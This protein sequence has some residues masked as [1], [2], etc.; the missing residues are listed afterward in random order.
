[1]KT[2]KKF[3]PKVI[4]QFFIDHT[5][6]LV[7]G[8][9]ALLFIYFAYNSIELN[10][11][12]AYTKKPDDLKKATD[13]ASARINNSTKD[14][15]VVT[16]FPAYA[17]EIDE[18][19]T[20]IDPAAYP[21]PPLWNW[22]P[23]APRRL[24]G[25]PEVFPV[26]NLRAIPGRG[27]VPDAAGTRGKRWIEITGLVPF[28]KE[29]AEYHARFDGAAYNDL[30]NDMPK[31]AGYFVQ[32]AEVTPGSEPVWSKSKF[33][34]F[35]PLDAD[36]MAG[37]PA[38]EVADARFV[39]RGLTA[40][41][42]SL[43]DATWGLDAVSPPQI[44]LA[45]RKKLVAA[46]TT[47]P[48]VPQFRPESGRR[49]RPSSTYRPLPST[50][51]GGTPAPNVVAG[52]GLLKDEDIDIPGTGDPGPTGEKPPPAP[53]YLLLRFLDF[54]VKPNKQYQYRIFLVLWN[55]NYGLEAGVLEESE[56]AESPWLGLKSPTPKLND[57]G[58][59][60]D[61]PTN[62][63]YAKWSAP[64]T[65]STD[66]GRHAAPG[67]TG[68]LRQAPARKQCGSARPALDGAVRTQ[69]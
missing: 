42:P 46:D 22:K 6:K 58:E 57:K 69:R 65:W 54:D 8:L 52:L 61:W 27:A 49:R 24:R 4:Q 50:S 40:P 60:V 19:K 3:D 14:P 37:Q 12:D 33:M 68:R 20:P 56:M 2:K 15:G 30:E 36:K 13:A 25:S 18:F 10:T 66:F 29:L 31:Y 1:M 32:R 28:K 67:R 35:P 43:V 63:K 44:P 64:C 16:A 39:S 59:M 17:E 51:P 21:M 47:Q 7:I 53:D 38:E 48:V 9:V 34:G 41:L 11:A 23:I 55:P 62:D 5:E 26:E 45:E